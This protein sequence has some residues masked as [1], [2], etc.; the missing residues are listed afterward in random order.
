M[1]DSEAPPVPDSVFE[2]LEQHPDLVKRWVTDR[3]FREEVVRSD[4]PATTA[5]QLMDISLHENTKDWI[6]E[7]VRVRTP[8]GLLEFRRPIPF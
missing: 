3:E 4:D 8:D 7:R 1:D 5:E 6:N 2:D